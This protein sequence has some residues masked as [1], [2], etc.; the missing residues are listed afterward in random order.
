[1]PRCYRMRLVLC[2]RG[3]LIATPSLAKIFILVTHTTCHFEH[4]ARLRAGRLDGLNRL[5]RMAHRLLL[6]PLLPCAAGWLLDLDIG[7]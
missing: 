5:L 2:R 4:I 3:P 1:M 6:A 7:R